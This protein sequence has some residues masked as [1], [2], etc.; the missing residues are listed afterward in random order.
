MKK[1]LF[2]V[3][4]F[5]FSFSLLADVYK[6][7]DEKG[8]VYFVDS[9][10]QVPF[11]YRRKMEI[12]P[13]G[14]DVNKQEKPFER[15][16]LQKN[17]IVKAGD[18]FKDFVFEKVKTWL[19]FVG[20]LFV[21]LVIIAFY[22]QDIWWGINFLLLFFLVFEGIYLFVFY[23]KV[24]RCTE[25]YSYLTRRYIARELKVPDRVKKDALEDV[26][27]RRPVP[28]NPFSYFGC[29]MRLEDFYNKIS[30]EVLVD[31]KK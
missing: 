5:V 8:R 2:F 26:L 12:L 14:K 28:L 21:F 15:F 9:I 20:F 4:L 29:I 6:Y 30:A 27:S 18:L 3:F 1:M 19:F 10:Y 16:L 22:L 17:G 23:P 7:T 31:R 24:K 25:V 13:S 11:N